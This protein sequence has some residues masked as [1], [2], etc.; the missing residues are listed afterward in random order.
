MQEGARALVHARHEDTTVRVWQLLATAGY[1]K[2]S[3]LR[4]SGN[5]RI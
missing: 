3:K 2:G 1:F 5:S 4:I